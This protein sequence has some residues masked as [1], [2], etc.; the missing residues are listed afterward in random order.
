M[1]TNWSNVWAGA[2][3]ILTLGLLIVTGIYAW[4]THRLAKAGEQQSW[5]MA[6]P[7]IVVALGSNQGG[8][9]VFLEIKNI[10]MTPAEELMLSFDRAVHQQFGG[11]DDIR[12]VP[13]LKEG[14]RSYP[15]GA[16]VRIGL[17]IGFSYLEDGVDRDRHPL[18]FTVTAKY[19]GGRRVLTEE[20][21]I[22]IHRQLRATL[23]DR[24]Y[25][26]DFARTFPD[27]FSKEMRALASALKSGR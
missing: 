19:T 17:G 24:N 15:P 10:G 14:V 12:E 8:Q 11:G 22:D 20:F 2:T 16:V 5:E 25:S 27:R 1:V 23:L 4:L 3:S 26:D 13:I 6:R 9:F 7:R 21:P 18:S